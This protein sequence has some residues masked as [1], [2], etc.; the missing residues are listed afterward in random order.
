MYQ[1]IISDEEKKILIDMC[2]VFLRQ[3]GLGGIQAVNRITTAI[4][5]AVPID[6]E[7]VARIK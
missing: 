1:M 6:Q 3:T 2:D 5:Q 7:K 4:N